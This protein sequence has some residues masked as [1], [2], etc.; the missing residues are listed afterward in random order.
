MKIGFSLS[1]SAIAAALLTASIA[2]ATPTGEFSIGIV[3][4]GSVNVNATTIDWRPP[5]GGGFGDFATG[6]PTTINYD[7]GT[8]TSSTNA[9]GRILDL[10]FAPVSVPNF[11]QFYVGGTTLPTPPGNAVL[12]PFPVFDL[13]QVLAGGSA[14]GVANDC[15]GVTGVGQ[16]CSPLIGGVFVSPFVLTNR[17]NGV[18]DVSLSVELLGRDSSGSATWFGG[19]TTQL[20]GTNASMVQTV[21]NGGGS[22][23]NTWSGTFSA[24]PVPEP[25]T[26][27]LLG[28][29]LFLF[30]YARRRFAR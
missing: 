30:G 16:S 24:A 5:V 19:F 27:M 20:T 4:G 15:A 23:N 26:Y 25:G 10:A 8:I 13:T 17:P 1:S 11:I 18:V 14:Q 2:S 28:S 3:T 6:E 29:G 22:I 9:F 12:Q 21:I 7:G